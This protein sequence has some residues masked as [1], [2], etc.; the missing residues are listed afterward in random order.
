MAVTRQV[1]TPSIKALIRH[2]IHPRASVD[3]VVKGLG[4]PVGGAMD[5]ED[6]AALRCVGCFVPQLG[7]A[8]CFMA[9]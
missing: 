5:K 9:G 4:R 2:L 1:K 6:W 3:G 7:M 8:T